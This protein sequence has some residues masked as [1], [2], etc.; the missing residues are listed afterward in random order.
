MAESDFTSCCTC[1]YFLGDGLGSCRRF[2]A[3]VTHHANEWCGEWAIKINPV[4]DVT[5]DIPVIKRG[6]PV[7]EAA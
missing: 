1:K 4:I 7:K 2:P 6:R 5:V 3:Y